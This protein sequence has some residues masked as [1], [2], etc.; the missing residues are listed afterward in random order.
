[1]SYYNPSHPPSVLPPAHPLGAVNG[2]RDVEGVAL[3]ALRCALGYVAGAALAPSPSDARIWGLVGIPVGALT[4][5][6][7]V[8]V[9]ALVAT[10]K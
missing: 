9:M 2:S 10:R 5:I 8:G 6:Y 4:G 1:M 3:F 7:G